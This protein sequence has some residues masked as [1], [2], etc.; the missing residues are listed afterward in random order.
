MSLVLAHG[1]MAFEVKTVVLSLLIF[2]LL[3][4]SENS[5]VYHDDFFSVFCFSG[6]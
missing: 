4:V 5:T 3:S 2:L 6:S 1:E